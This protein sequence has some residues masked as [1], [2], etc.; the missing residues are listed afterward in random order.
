M[1]HIFNTE[2]AALYGIEEAIL[3]ENLHFWI[4]KNE[5]NEKHFYDGDYWTYS[6]AK[7]YA[8][9]F[10]YMSK[11][12]IK[13]HLKKLKDA[14]LIKTGNYNKSPYDRTNWYALTEKSRKFFRW[15]KN[16]PSGGQERPIQNT[17]VPSL[18]STDIISDVISIYQ[19]EDS[20]LK[21]DNPPTSL[22]AA[23]PPIDLIDIP[24]P[25]NISQTVADNISL[26][27][28]LEEYPT[29]SDDIQAVNKIM[30][31]VLSSTHAGTVRIAKTDT[32]LS[33][34]KQKLMTIRKSHVD[35]VLRCLEKNDN[36][37]K[38]STNKTGYLL[39]ALFNSVRTID[40]Y[41]PP[42]IK[43]Q[44]TSAPLTQI[45]KGFNEEH[46]MAK[47]KRNQAKLL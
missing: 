10:P 6:S 15:G 29:Y 47:I 44:D 35:Y 5:A 7:A 21:S 26:D 8:E 16:V 12:K 34:V 46:I 14:D 40:L 4:R 1:H 28:L 25:E 3:L 33:D 43:K 13:R 23:T 20:V 9:L 39:T 45:P 2:V 38:I 22:E 30:C 17:E 27:E 24:E 37:K 18:L 31:T 42:P 32:P 41:S 36:G 19:E 11:D